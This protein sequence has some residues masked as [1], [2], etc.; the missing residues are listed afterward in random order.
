VAVFYHESAEKE[1][2]EIPLVP[3]KLIEYDYTEVGNLNKYS[4]ISIYQGTGFHLRF[5]TPSL[6]FLVLFSP[7][8]NLS[9]WRN[10]DMQIALLSSL[11]TLFWLDN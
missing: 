7:P 6:L 3:F 1:T 2:F 9:S 10:V 4:L 8:R 5:D 11:S